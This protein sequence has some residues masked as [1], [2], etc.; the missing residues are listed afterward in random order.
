[1][2]ARLERDERGAIMLMGVFMA[3]FL[4]A[5]LYYIVGIGEAIWQRER[6]QD[7][8]DAA[9]FSAAVLHA[10]GMNLLVLINMVMAA[11]LAVLVTLKLVETL[12][13]VAM[14]A[15]AFA[16][17]LQ[18]GLAAAIPDLEELRGQVSQAH[19]WLQP[20]ID[21]ALETLHE[22]GRA[23]RVV[24]PAAS[25]I[26]AIV[27]EA[28]SYDPP[29][30][31]ALVLPARASLPTR[32]GTFDELCDKAGGYVGDTTKFVLAKAVPPPVAR[33]VGNAVED[34]TKSGAA[35]F[36]GSDAV[37]PPSTTVEDTAHYPTLPSRA[38][39]M[40]QDPTH[41]GDH[42]QHMTAV[43]TQAEQDEVDSE[44]D[45]D[46][47]QCVQRCA[48]DEPYEQRDA[49][50]RTQCAP[51]RKGKDRLRDFTFQERTFTRS[52]L[53]KHGS[54]WVTSTPEAE[55]QSAT[56]TRKKDQP[57]PC[58]GIGSVGPDWNLEPH[59]VA[60]TELMPLCSSGAPVVPGHE[61]QTL[62]VEQTE[63]TRLFGCSQKVERHYDLGAHAKDRLHADDDGTGSKKVP[64]VM[65]K[66]VELGE[67]DFQLRAAALGALPS[68]AYSRVLQTATWKAEDPNAVSVWS[69]ARQLGRISLAQAEYFYA[70]EDPK[71]DEAESYMWNMRWQARLR[72]FRLPTKNAETTA[73]TDEAETFGAGRVFGSFEEACAGVEPSGGDS[74][75]SSPCKDLDLSISDLI[76]H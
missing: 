75:S 74:G 19:D 67:D 60:D 76:V 36:C 7:A 8:A 33:L 71:A 22:V 29:A 24:V 1:M 56:Y 70:V 41:T 73:P 30:H 34:L 55:E 25:E 9:A 42:A 65:A 4:T 11:L 59:P 72:R 45:A 21:T 48:P 14:V 64:Q 3:V 61:G 26:P 38:E 57:R 43:C 52:Y 28:Q 49:A 50:A 63:I 54:W 66:G 5:A 23:V 32:D 62:D 6:M 20:P 40:Q 47:G 44:P 18:P 31:F 2:T 46:S 10:R 35:W 17:F 16:S 58:A 27:G 37:D 69:T 53:F 12:I 51:P 13:I 68:G 15:I 39:C